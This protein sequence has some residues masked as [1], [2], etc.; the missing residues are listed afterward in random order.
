MAAV[1]G[2][3]PEDAPR[4]AR[5]ADAGSVRLSGRDVSGLLLCAEHYAAPYDLL[6][7][8]LGVQPARLRGVVARWRAAGLAQTGVLGP[9]PAWCWLTSAGM[10][11]CGLGYP[12]RPPALAR[13][14]HIRAVLAAR[15]WLQSG[16][17]YADWRA[18]WR[19]ERRI[20]AGLPSNAGA[21]HVPDAEIHW[22]S[23][24]ASPY[25]GQ[26]WAVEAELTPKPAART[27]RIM[28]GL[29]SPPRYAQ[30]VYLTAPAARPVVARVAAT[31]PDP[32]RGRVAVRDL[33]MAALLREV[34]R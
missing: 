22:P 31:L 17:A 3:E 32:Q 16:P 6:A 7:A 9:G 20:R 29:L 25:A 1:T 23:V 15:L 12:A 33:P 26:V 27:Q 19:S 28:A 18:W 30:V 5:R 4:Q 24:E 21:A 2:L 13:L 8:A 34:A 10:A 11:A 14:A